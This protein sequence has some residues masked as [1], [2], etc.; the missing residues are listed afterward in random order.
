MHDPVWVFR[1]GENIER[2]LLI[3]VSISLSLSLSL[4]LVVSTFSALQSYGTQVFATL[5]C[6]MDHCIL[7]ALSGQYEYPVARGDIRWT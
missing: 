2:E 7:I 1:L 4:S 5:E 6:T 3:H